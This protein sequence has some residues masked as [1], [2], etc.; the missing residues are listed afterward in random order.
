M[1]EYADTHTMAGDV[2]LFDLQE[3]EEALRPGTGAASNG[4][5]A[6]TLF[7]QGALRATLVSFEKDGRMDDH[8]AS[9][10]VSVQV[11]KG[12]VM[13]SVDGRESQLVEGALVTI[14][15]H[16]RHSVQALD[17]AAILV[18]VAFGG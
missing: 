13:L 1:S 12:T 18:T 11:L 15:A 14:G 5:T 2:L 16:V 7:K 6:K 3:E 8:Q 10:P 4:L 17:P 9:G